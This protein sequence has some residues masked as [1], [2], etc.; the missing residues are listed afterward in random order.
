MEAAAAP[1]ALQGIVVQMR[2]VL[3]SEII[4]AIRNLWGLFEVATTGAAG[5]CVAGGNYEA[6]QAL[7]QRMTA[8]EDAGHGIMKKV[9]RLESGDVAV[10][11]SGGSSVNSLTQRVM[12]LE[13]KSGATGRRSG[14]IGDIPSLFSNTQESGVR[15][16]SGGGRSFSGDGDRGGDW[17]GGSDRGG[18]GDQGVGRNF[19]EQDPSIAPRLKTIEAKLLDLEAQMDNITVSM[20]GFQFKSV[21]D[22][23]AFILK[24]VPGNTFAYFYDIVSLL[25]RAW[26][27]NHIGVREVWENSY[28]LKK[29]GFK[30]QGEAVILASM[31]TV[32]PTCLGELTGKNSECHLPLPALATHESWTSKGFQ[33]GRRKDIQDGLLRVVTTLEDNIREMFQSFEQGRCVVSEMLS[34]ARTHWSQMERMIDTFFAE[35]L[36][37]GTEKD[38]WKL[39]SLIAKTVF[40]AVHQVRAIGSDLSDLVSPSKKAAKVMW[41]TLQAHRVMRTFINAD[42]RNDPR[43][44]P[45]IVLHL[46]E[47][48]VG[49]AD[50]DAIKQKVA[51]QTVRMDCQAKEIDKLIQTVN[52]L[53]RRGAGGVAGG[54][55]G[56]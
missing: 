31:D 15:F 36:V 41:A 38:A 56:S 23:E 14:A 17:D 50:V 37:T 44:A 19:S 34:L 43:I 47:N 33:M 24:H 39:T 13:R 18:G 48:R 53:K 7:L 21:D 10:A 3:V 29:A 12:A 8:L 22:C 30:S 6:G 49:R 46:L 28:A 9:Q 27:H 11:P 4:P 55:A 1:D 51:L 25:Q 2:S 32:L 16:G 45:V 20:G 5:T 42:F 54:R 35:F 40:E 26:G 52:E